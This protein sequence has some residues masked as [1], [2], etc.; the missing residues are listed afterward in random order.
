MGKRGDIKIL[1]DMHFE[2]W[3]KKI[4]EVFSAFLTIPALYSFETARYIQAGGVVIF[5]STHTHIFIGMIILKTGQIPL[6]IATTV[7]RQ[8]DPHCPL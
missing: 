3:G 5:Y 4:H 2:L 7:D 1:N 8:C 6:I